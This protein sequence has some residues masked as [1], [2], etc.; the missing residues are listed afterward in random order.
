MIYFCADDYGISAMSNSRIEQC[1]YK[2]VLNK[3]SVLPNGELTDF[4]NRLSAAGAV[5]SLHLNFVEGKALSA[6]G[7]LDLITTGDGCFKYS[8]MGLLALSLSPKRKQLEKQLYKEMR[9]QILFW[10][11][12]MGAQTPVYIDSHQH[13][14]IIPLLFK[15]LMRIIKEEN[16]A[17]A[18]IRIAAEPLAPYLL[19]PSLYFSYKPKGIIKQWVLRLLALANR[20]NIKN[21]DLHTTYFMG[22]MFSGEMTE[23]RIKTLLPHY[24]KLA[25][26]Q[27]KDVEIALHP[28]YVRNSGDLPDT[29]RTSFKKFYLSAWRKRE[30]DTLMH[31]HLEQ[32]G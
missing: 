1:L 5:L 8:F 6:P 20:R 23:D 25:N 29:V 7:D 30:F 24:L 4:K 12:Q 9:A 16:L 18:S 32:Q 17:I 13:T 15:T 26:K 3:V 21:S 10:K 22:A 2:G 27:G 14:L 28:G 31:F 11:E 19:S